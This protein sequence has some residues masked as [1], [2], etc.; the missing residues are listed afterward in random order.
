MRVRCRIFLLKP[1][2]LI[3]LPVLRVICALD[4]DG[5]LETETLGFPGLTPECSRLAGINPARLS[6]RRSDGSQYKEN[7][8]L[9]VKPIVWRAVAEY[10]AVIY[11]HGARAASQAFY[12]NASA[13][14]SSESGPRCVTSKACWSIAFITTRYALIDSIPSGRRHGLN[15]DLISSVLAESQLQDQFD[16]FRAKRRQT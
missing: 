13:P 10:G 11:N 15:S 2:S 14:I 6:A 5:V 1:T 9:A 8:D 3:W 7:A 4:I 12:P 16:P